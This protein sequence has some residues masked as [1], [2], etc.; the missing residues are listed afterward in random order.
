MVELNARN[1]D[2]IYSPE[3]VKPKP[4]VDTTTMQPNGY[5]NNQ[6]GNYQQIDVWDSSQKTSLGH[7]YQSNDTV[8][9]GYIDDNAYTRTYSNPSIINNYYGYDDDYYYTRRALGFNPYGY[10]CYDDYYYNPYYYNYTWGVHGYWGNPYSNFGLYWSTPLFI[11]S[12]P[13]YNQHVYGNYP[14]SGHY[15]NHYSQNTLRRRFS[16]NDGYAASVN[17]TRQ[18]SQTT[19]ADATSQS[20][21][22]GGTTETRNA[23]GSRTRSN[24]ESYSQTQQQRQQSRTGSQAGTRYYP[25]SSEYDGRRPAS[26]SSDA[27]GSQRSTRGSGAASSG[28]SSSDNSGRRTRS[29]NSGSGESG[30]G[31]SEGS[32]SYSRPSSSGSS[33]GSSSGWGGS[34]GSS[35]GGSS[36]GGSR[37]SSG[38]S[39]GGGGYS[40]RR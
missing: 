10:S 31:S 32:G 4:I 9:N 36:D 14:R 28:S 21:N 27:Y 2:E 23:Q 3:K 35:G 19:K 15:S 13:Y 22:Q 24:A 17:R 8:F 30:S 34:R 7:R 37:G 1:D 40:R 5:N 16:F 26:S 12:T 11:Y 6:N 25:R 20:R 39:S 33:G 18:N 29:W 38:G